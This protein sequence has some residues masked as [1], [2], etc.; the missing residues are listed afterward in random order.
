MRM[1]TFGRYEILECSNPYNSSDSVV[2]II[3]GADVKVLNTDLQTH[4][5][6]KDNIVNG[7]IEKVSFLIENKDHKLGIFFI[8]LLTELSKKIEPVLVPQP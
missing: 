1:L 4:I 2:Q 8:T 5:H 7:S 3:Q 6:W